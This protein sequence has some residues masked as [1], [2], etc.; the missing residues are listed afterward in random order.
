MNS[1][2]SDQEKH[3]HCV[4]IGC[5]IGFTDL[6]RHNELHT[7]RSTVVECSV[8]PEECP[9]CI[10]DQE[11][12]HHWSKAGKCAFPRLPRPIYVFHVLFYVFHV[13][14]VLFPRPILRLPRLPR[15]IS[16]SYLRLPRPIFIICSDR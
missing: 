16:T 15:P 5:D 2:P 13:F 3:F 14:H 12:Q 4:N 7:V 11:K 9:C 1:P 6:Q 8:P 10:N